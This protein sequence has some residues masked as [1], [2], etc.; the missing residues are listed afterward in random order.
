[1]AL[2]SRCKCDS[3]RTQQTW[4]MLCPERTRCAW[5]S[6]GATRRTGMALAMVLASLLPKAF[7]RV[8]GCTCRLRRLA[9]ADLV[10][11]MATSGLAS[12]TWK[13]T[14]NGKT[15]TKQTTPSRLTTT[16]CSRMQTSRMKCWELAFKGWPP[17]HMLLLWP[18]VK[19]QGS[20]RRVSPMLWPKKPTCLSGWHLWSH[21]P[22]VVCIEVMAML[23]QRQ[24]M[25][26][27]STGCCWSSLSG[28]ALNG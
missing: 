16:T 10:K 15:C 5:S 28:M 22:T 3:E 27:R 1:M 7:P 2:N 17:V 20:L 9:A 8:G 18:G 6:Y 12:L 24:L 23:L 13:T 25:A 4:P 19:S 21:A 11:A 14:T 26:A